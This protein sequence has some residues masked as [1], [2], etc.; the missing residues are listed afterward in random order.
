[1]PVSNPPFPYWHV[2]SGDLY[3]NT[4]AGMGLYLYCGPEANNPG[5]GSNASQLNIYSG[6]AGIAGSGTSTGGLLY[7]RS[8]RAKYGSVGSIA[9]DVYIHASDTG[10]SGTGDTYGGNVKIKAGYAQYSGHDAKGG[11]ITLTAGK[12]GGASRYGHGGNIGIYAGDSDNGSMGSTGGNV[13]IKPGSA[14]SGAYKTG[15]YLIMTLG[16]GADFPAQMLMENLPIANPGIPNAVWN[17]SGVLN[18][19]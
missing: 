5:G 7:L 19:V 18:I 6:D 1:M 15:G 16:S 8:G 13:R 9:G 12:S 17:N 3:I 4:P 11:D 10:N 2:R 14:P